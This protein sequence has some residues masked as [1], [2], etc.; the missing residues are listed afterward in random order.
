MR[1]KDTIWNFILPF[2]GER[3]DD[4]GAGDAGNVGEAVRDIF[5]LSQLYTLLESFSFHH[6]HCAVK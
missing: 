1:K 5:L 4:G 3:G 6:F 2:Q